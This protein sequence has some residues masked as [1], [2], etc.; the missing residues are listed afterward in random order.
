MIISQT[1]AIYVILLVTNLI[2]KSSNIENEKAENSRKIVG[3]TTYLFARFG[4]G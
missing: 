2:S 1:S 4:A 3:W